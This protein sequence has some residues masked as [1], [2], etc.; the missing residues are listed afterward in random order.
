MLP[1]PILIL[2]LLCPMVLLVMVLLRR[3]FSLPA[4]GITSFFR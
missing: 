4:G 3:I 2:L 1:C